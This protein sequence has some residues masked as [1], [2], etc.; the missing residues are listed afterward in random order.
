MRD[1]IVF[2]RYGGRGGQ[3]GIMPPHFQRTAIARALLLD[4]HHAIERL[5]FGAKPRQTNHQH[6]NSNSLVAA[7]RGGRAVYSEFLLFTS[8]ADF[9]RENPPALSSSP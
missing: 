9:Q 7:R 5:L 4:H 6:S 8:P 2:Q 1:P 3:R